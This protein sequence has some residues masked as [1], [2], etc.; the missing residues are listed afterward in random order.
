MRLQMLVVLCLFG[1]A[2]C[3]GGGGSSTPLPVAPAP[4]TPPVPPPAPVVGAAGGTVTESS[5]A[6]IIVPAGALS[7]DTTIRIARD[8]TG[9]PPL[10][11]GLA[12]AGSMYMLT[13]HGG[14]FAEGVTVRLPLPDVALQ[15]N[16]QF[17]IAKAQPGGEWQLLED[18]SPD[19]GGLAV[20]VNSFSFFQVVTV[21]YLL[22]IA[23][24][25]PFSMTAELTCAP[26]CE[27]TLGAVTAT[28]G[29]TGNGGQ[30]PVQCSNTL[31][32][33]IF[34]QPDRLNFNLVGAGQRVAIAQTGGTL[35]LSLEPG[36][37]GS[38]RFG[39]ARKCGLLGSWTENRSLERAVTWPATPNYPA[40]YIHS[41]FTPTQLDVVQGLVANVDAVLSGGAARA[42]ENVFVTP[43]PADHA[44]IDWERSDDTG[45]SWRTVARTFQHEADPL[46]GGVG[47]PWRFWGVR[48]GFVATAGD[49]GALLRIRACY[50]PPAGVAAEPCV[51]GA[52][53][54][55]NLLQQSA[56]PVITSPPRSVLV[57]TGQ[58]ASFAVT[59]A[60]APAPTLQWQTRPANSTG[61]W[62]NVSAGTGA[63]TPNYTTAVTTLSDNGMQYR[64]VATN[65]VASVESTGVTV[66]VSDVD[67]APSISTQPAALSVT[68]G[69][70]AVFAVD[71]RGTEA[72]SYQW[73]RDGALITGANS[74]VL[75]LTGVTSADAGS[76]LVTVGN[77][78]GVTSSN[79]AA[80][81]VTAGSPA[82]VAPSIV[83]QPVSINA[84][85]GATATFAVGVDGTGPFTYQWRREGANI[86]GATSAVYSIN[87]AALPQAGAYSVVVSNGAGSVTSA[88]AVLDVT[89]AAAFLPPS[90]TSQPATVIVPAL[91]S[92]TIAVGATG[93]GPLAYQ[94]YQNGDLQVGAT[95]PVLIFNSV[96]EAQ[97]GSWVVTVTNSVGTVTSQAAQVILLGAPTIVQQPEDASALEGEIATFFVVANGSGL[98]YQWSMNGT[99]LP[100]YTAATLR[101]EPLLIANSG[102]VYSVLVYN[103]AGLA[104]SQSAV[105][106]VQTMVAPSIVQHPADVSIDAGSQAP[107]CVT[108][109][110]TPVFDVQLERWNGAT[111]VSGAGVQVNGNSQAC[112]F[113]EPLGTPDN[114]AQF[115]FHVA[116]PAGQ[117]N[118]NTA[119]V[120]V[121]TPS[122]SPVTGTTLVSRAT[123]G[124]LPDNISEQ[125]SISAN[126]RY[127]AFTSTGTNLHEDAPTPW[128]AYVRDMLTGETRLVN[129]NLNGDVSN[130]G[131]G[132][133][134]ISANGRYVIFTSRANDLVAGDTNNSLDVF[135]RDLLTGTNLRVNVLPDGAQL[136]F[137]A[138]GNGDYHLGISAD[139][140]VVT[141]RCAYDLLGNGTA[142]SDYFLYRRDL[143]SGGTQLVAGSSVYP[144]AYNALSD[145]GRW[146]AYSYGVPTP[147][148]QT[149]LLYDAQA[150]TSTPV[151]S[152]FAAALPDGLQ[153]GMS[154][155]S[156]GRYVAFALISQSLLGS[157]RSQVVVQ[158]RD[159]SARYIAS[160]TLGVPGD[161]GSVWPR[162]SGDG[163]YVAFSTHAPSL[164]NNLATPSEAYVVIG[165]IL[166]SNLTIA[167]RRPNGAEVS[168]GVFANSGHALSA[169]GATL[170]FTADYNAVIGGALGNQVFATPRT[171]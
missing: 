33:A 143:S 169:D 150:N 61:Q 103:S 149:V 21:T 58:T 125:P 89:A 7:A 140:S 87:F 80:L 124:V 166:E 90:I 44:I 26:R 96:A 16:Q 94:W 155:S 113:T 36:P 5:G 50:T 144:V 110:G 114:G 130:Q 31:E 27:G 25:P 46:P 23:Q 92:A 146:V 30:L 85:E 48:H 81:T 62:T 117:V 52:P 37:F 100:G 133:V 148:T 68:S 160:A 118:S 135:R 3:G 91:G 168:A 141:F 8:S 66:S 67:V 55:I 71:A 97:L 59:A 128:N 74:P 126:G 165:D 47:L 162:I 11:G 19:A 86:Q 109:G 56:L 93:S 64:V 18:T 99:P 42:V 70:D 77:S 158:D 163:R 34:A 170:A 63:T 98:R 14:D 82:A 112:Y 159:S 22:P 35:T 41:Q 53:V 6:S 153:P 69:G 39:V 127:V 104:Y 101:T 60:G 107:M 15:P 32:W 17:Q 108:I 116:N 38:Y 88:N 139:G 142:N 73:M 106:T 76:Y 137:G 20:K 49:Q 120:T 45:R 123:S 134:N 111:W 29:V 119:T 12:A 122:V 9:A 131:V 105:L 24:V 136:E 1:L 79:A 72:L 57:R 54:R 164:T 4:P 167:S 83:T 132:N 138:G 121:R 10:P 28:Y 2:G 84:N 115:R 152:T 145:D 161:G 151:F 40:I 156:D 51:T 65:A 154:I 13:P 43:G 78:A 75:R 157:S 171:Q 95:S 129:Y 102:A 147:G